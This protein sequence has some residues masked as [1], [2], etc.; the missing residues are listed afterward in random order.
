MLLSEYL[1]KSEFSKQNELRRSLLIAFYNLR[2]DLI[3]EFTILELSNWLEKIGYSRPN[4]GRLRSNLKK[5]RMFVA[6]REIDHFKIHPSTI[7][8][9]DSEFPDLT[10]KTEAVISHDSIIPENL[11]QEDRAFIRSLIK[12]INSSYENNIFDGCAVLMRR[13]LEILLI[14]AYEEAKLKQAIQDGS[15]NY[16]Q[17]NSIIDDAEKNTSLGLSRNT[18]EH[19]DSFRKLGNFSAH[20]IYYN[21]NRKDIESSILDFRAAVE[22]LLYKSGLRT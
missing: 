6:A 8:T 5:S 16:K 12:Q 17:L 15:G 4:I 3:S 19:L 11:L 22:E 14:L 10:K 20:K 21:A 2:I 9:L 7:E 1:I 18:R 13:L